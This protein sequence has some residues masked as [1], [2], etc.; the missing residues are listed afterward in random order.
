MRLLDDSGIQTQGFAAIL[1][2]EQQGR[3][4]GRPREEK[5]LRVLLARLNAARVP[6][7]MDLPGADLHP[8][9]GTMVGF[10]AVSVS[11]NWRL[12]F[13]FSGSDADDVDYVD[14]H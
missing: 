2:D 9:K 12:T 4:S 10:W 6:Q 7:D 1:R 11:G 14:Y 5:R 3:D 8:L 13:R